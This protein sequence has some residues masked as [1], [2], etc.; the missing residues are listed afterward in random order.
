M[1]KQIL[2]TPRRLRT[3]ERGLA[4]ADPL[5][6]ALIARHGRCLLAPEPDRS[7]YEALATA[8]MY[9]QLAGK[10]AETIHRR[11][12]ALFP[13]HVFPPPA[14]VLAASDEQLRSAG[15]SRQKQAYLRDLAAKALEGVVPMASGE[16]EHLSSDAIVARLAAV[17]GVGRWTVEMFLIFTLGRIDVLPLD[18]YGICTGYARAYGQE[19]LPSAS[20]LRAAGQRWAPWRS[21]ATWYLWRAA[22]AP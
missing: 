5:L 7:P 21:V 3:A 11:F 2:I 10:A 8:V 4:A 12:L 22:D 20:E 1:T 13:E 18:D 14:A 16:L 6:A 19:R 9:Q 17:R 15:L